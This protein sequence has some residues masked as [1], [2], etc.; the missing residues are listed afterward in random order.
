MEGPITNEVT[1]P[2][3]LVHRAKS[4]DAAA[5]GELYERYFTPVYRYLFLRCGDR[6]LAEDLSQTVF[7]KAYQSVASLRDQGRPPLA[8]L[9][10]I[11]RNSLIDYWRK[12]RE[13]PFD[14]LGETARTIPTT[15]GDP[16]ETASSHEAANLVRSAIRGLTDS[17]QE[18]IILKF[19]NELSNR[20]VAEIL[21]KSEA[22]VRQLQCRG[23]RAL[24][25][26]LHGTI[27]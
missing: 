12:K 21:G 8:Y 5:F 26:A 15:A 6:L 18:V 20:E 16:R 1:D 23:L 4:G 13:V 9:F 11:A 27:S 19:L 17:E 3:E 10:T 24:R 22:A 7:L 2:W 25:K 14:V